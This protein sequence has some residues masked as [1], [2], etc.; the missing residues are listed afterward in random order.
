M[1]DYKDTFGNVFFTDIPV[2]KLIHG[3]SKEQITH[4]NFDK[5]VILEE[6]EKKFLQDTN[7]LKFYEIFLG[8]LQ[9]SFILFFFGQNFEGFEQWKKIICLLCQCE[10]AIYT[11]KDLFINFIPVVYEQL[12]QL[13]KDFLDDE[14][15][16]GVYFEP[17]SRRKGSSLRNNFIIES[18]N[19]FYEI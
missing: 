15:P 17:N 4:S 5:S 6:L 18:L 2:R 11:Q 3:F 16:N 19:S 14:N 12:D 1:Y 7:N 8:E 10:E 9:F 13:P